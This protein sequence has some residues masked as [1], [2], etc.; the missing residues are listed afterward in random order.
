MK[1][2]AEG[3]GQDPHPIMIRATAISRIAFLKIF[4]A[5]EVRIICNMVSDGDKHRA[6]CLKYSLLM[7]PSSGRPEKGVWT[8]RVNKP[9]T[10]SFSLFDSTNT[11]GKPR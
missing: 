3:G 1:K 7:Y 4:F 8:M 9:C 2:N 6:G 10:G 5:R 11:S